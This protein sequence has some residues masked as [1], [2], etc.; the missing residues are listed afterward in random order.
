M[1]EFKFSIRSIVSHSCLSCVTSAR[2]LY[3]TP[4]KS[5]QNVLRVEG[6]GRGLGTSRHDKV[7][8]GGKRGLGAGVLEQQSLIYSVFRFFFH[9]IDAQALFPEE[10]S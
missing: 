6:R 2:D 7:I 4:D 8:V 1:P 5:K 10:M 9:L 3:A